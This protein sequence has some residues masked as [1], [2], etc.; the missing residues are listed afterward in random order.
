M[1][2]HEGLVVCFYG[3]NREIRRLIRYVLVLLG[4]IRLYIYETENEGKQNQK[5][6]KATERLNGKSGIKANY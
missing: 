2:A 6:L 1:R 3:K 5:F 4:M